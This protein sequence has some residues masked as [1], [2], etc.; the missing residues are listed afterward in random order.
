MRL[1]L[2]ILVGLLLAT[3]AQ[4]QSQC[5]PTPAIMGFL[6]SQYGEAQVGIGQNASGALVAIT[7]SPAGTWSLVLR[8]PDGLTCILTSG[9]NWQSNAPE[10]APS[11][12]PGGQAPESEYR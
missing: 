2:A 4:A 5:G 10:D 3:S 11:P 1:I 12:F 6:A 7:A 8:R 9:E